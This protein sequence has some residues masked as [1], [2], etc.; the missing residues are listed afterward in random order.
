M[1]GTTYSYTVSTSVPQAG[2]VGAIV[3]VT[4]TSDG[5]TAIDISD[6][7]TKQIK[8]TDPEGNDITKA[9]AF[10]TDGTDGILT[11]TTVASDTVFASAGR[12]LIQAYVVSTAAGTI[13]S[14]KTAQH[15]DSVLS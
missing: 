6:A 3:K 5:S 15:V 4:I 10:F 14:S 7:T 1:A 11:Y 8:F 12:W 2:D 9:A 13:H